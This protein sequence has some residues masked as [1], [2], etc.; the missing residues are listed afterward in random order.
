MML[1]T[2]WTSSGKAITTERKSYPGRH[3]TSRHVMPRHVTSCHVTIPRRAVLSIS[4]SGLSLRKLGITCGVNPS[5]TPESD[6]C[7]NSPTASQEIWHHTV[8]R[9]WLFIAYSDEK[10][11]YYKFS[12]HQSYN[13]FLKG[14]ENTLF[15]LRSERVKSLR[16][17][18]NSYEQ[19]WDQTSDEPGR[20]HHARRSPRKVLRH[21]LPGQRSWCYWFHFGP[22]RGRYRTESRSWIYD[23][24]N[25]AESKLAYFYDTTRVASNTSSATSHLPTTYR[26]P[27]HIPTTHRS[28]LPTTYWPDQPHTDHYWPPLPTIIEWLRA[29]I[30][31]VPFRMKFSSMS[32]S[33]QTSQADLCDVKR[34]SCVFFSV[35]AGRKDLT[36]RHKSQPPPPSPSVRPNDIKRI[37][38][39]FCRVPQGV[40]IS[41]IQIL[42]NCRL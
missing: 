20:S 23:I 24:R 6:Q 19:Y 2:L 35:K 15:E 40:H 42:Q 13:R 11:L 41:C 33:T 5:F 14:W 36:N 38:A 26:P 12:L 17:S 4:A 34:C 10:W 27:D 30:A 37:L 7:Q 8:W 22:Q 16:C 29:T 31:L 18:P 1:F 32:E 28:P 9:T 39:G 25:Q 3:I 21:R